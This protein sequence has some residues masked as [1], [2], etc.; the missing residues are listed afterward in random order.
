MRWDIPLN[1]SHL[2]ES[3]LQ[4]ILNS[5]RTKEKARLASFT[6]SRLNRVEIP[7]NRVEILDELLNSHVM[8]DVS[9]YRL[10]YINIKDI[11]VFN[12]LKIKN[13]YNSYYKSI[14]FEEED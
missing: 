6:S 11:I 10:A 2:S 1:I 13:I 5:S 3:Y 7:E 8:V 9:A 4:L 14:F 12:T